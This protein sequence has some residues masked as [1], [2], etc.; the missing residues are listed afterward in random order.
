[1]RK[2]DKI[3]WGMVF[4]GTLWLLGAILILALFLTGSLSGSFSIPK[5]LSFFYEIFGVLIGSIVQIILSFSILMCGIFE[6]GSSEKNKAM[7]N[8]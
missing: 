1:M 7:P 6:F 8:S 2:R 4:F 3:S 5:V